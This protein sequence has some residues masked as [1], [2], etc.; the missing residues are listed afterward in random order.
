MNTYALDFETYYDKTCSIKTLGPLGY[1]S[2][3]DFD[4][5]M[6][7]VVGD[8]GYEFVGHPKDFEWGILQGN[9]VLSH[10]AS[11]DETLYKYGVK[12]GL[13]P[14]VDYEAWYCT[15][16][17]CAYLGL[18]RNLA[19][20]S[21]EALGFT[22]DKT[23][24][25]NMMGKRWESM[26]E[27]FRREVEEYALIDSRLCLDLWKKLSPDWP[28]HE[29]EISRVNREALQNGIPIDEQE[30]ADALIRVRQYL[31]DAESSIPWHGQDKT[32]SRTAFNDECRKYGVEPPVSLAKNNAEAQAWIKEH[33]HK[34]RWVTAVTEWRRI[35]SMLRKLE[36]IQNATMSDGRYYGN[37][38]YW[39]AHT[40]R[41]SGGGGNFNLQNLPRKEM[42]GA[43]LRKLITAPE[44]KKLVVVDLSQIEVRT[45]LW[46]ARDT[47]T[48]REVEQTDDIYETF[49]IKF[50]M[51]SPEQGSLRDHDPDLRS[52]VK[53]IVLGAGF[54]AGKKAFAAAYGYS[55][56]DSENA[57]Q[58][59][60]EK[61]PC[62]EALWGDLRRKIQDSTRFDKEG[63][64]KPCQVSLMPLRVMD[65][66]P[67]T[68]S[69]IKRKDGQSEYTYTEYT[70]KIRKHSKIVPVRLWA[71]LVTEN[72]AQGL[73]RDIF[74]DILVRLEKRGHKI[75]FHVHDEVILETDEDK[76]DEVLA[77]VIGIMSDPPD[78]I[79]DIPLAAEGNVLTHYEK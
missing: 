33:G 70:A 10:N 39:G 7:S 67:L 34:F 21:E 56:E 65:Y 9:I 50:D 51:W 78:W 31:H 63:Q 58:I 53:A 15:A 68:S 20:A 77:E 2:H 79:P 49:A 4:A 12:E 45:L 8:D 54:M 38:M 18:A 47:K 22:H 57:I 64:P 60:R 48:L 26:T 55:E 1:F 32:L 66:G 62:V 30:L 5:Y 14:S 69:R 46:L 24:R 29:R 25:S 27:D 17:L 28:H 52:L 75:L 11:F 37:I 35:N 42:F 73:A 61:M 44:G 23:T 72:L 59:Y 41:F 71:G 19:G 13:W 40:G 16:D 3:P 43:D 74:A 6:V 76:A 36:A